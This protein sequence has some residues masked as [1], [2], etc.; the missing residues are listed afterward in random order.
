M[1]WMARLLGGLG[2]TVQVAAAQVAPARMTEQK[3]DIAPAISGWFWRG[4]DARDDIMQ[5]A[6]RD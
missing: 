2:V 5:E 6:I 3:E 1:N 4:F